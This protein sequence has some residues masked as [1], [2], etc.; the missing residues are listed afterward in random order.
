[1]SPYHEAKKMTPPITIKILDGPESLIANIFSFCQLTAGTEFDSYKHPQ[2]RFLL[3]GLDIIALVAQI[4]SQDKDNVD[5]YG[6]QT[7]L[8]FA[9][10]VLRVKINDDEDDGVNETIGYGMVIVSPSQRK[11]GVATA[12][13]KRALEMEEMRNN[14]GRRVLAVCSELGQP[15]YRKLGFREVGLISMM[16]CKVSDIRKCNLPINDDLKCTAFSGNELGE[17]KCILFDLDKKATGFSRRKR[18]D[19]L[20]RGYSEG[21][22][23]TVVFACSSSDEAGVAPQGVAIGRQDFV[24][25][26]FIIGP[27][28]GSEKFFLPMLNELIHNHFD[29]SCDL[30]NEIG[31][32]FMIS[33]HRKLVNNLLEVENMARLWECPSMSLDGEPVYRNGDGS[34]IAMMHPT[35]G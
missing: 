30:N 13:L 5:D 9:G 8:S 29:L 1:M 2:W 17:R 4:N 3:S 11:K 16:A 25:G 20:L 28:I 26:P 14:R 19:L 15:M 7:A 10:C 32:T 24:G 6:L 33:N 18:I 22:S 12:L 34:Y 35:L 31:V 27:T 21:N 23:C